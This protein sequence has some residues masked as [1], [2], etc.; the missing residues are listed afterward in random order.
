MYGKVKEK[1]IWSYWYDPSSCPTSKSCVM[2]PQVELCV[3]T[4]QHNKGGFD[5]VVLHM[6]TV[7][8]YLNGY[9]LPFH[10]RELTAPHQ[11]D[12][13]MNALLAR[14][15]GVALDIS[16]IVLRP[17]DPWWEEMVARGATFR[18]YVYRLDGRP[19]RHAE[20]TAVWFM[21]SRRE[22]IFSAATRSQVEGMGDRRNVDG[23]YHD[24]NFALGDQTVTPILSKFNYSLPKCFQDPSLLEP[25]Q[26]CPEW[27]QPPWYEG[28]SG[29]ERNDTWLMLEDPRTGPHLPFAMS[30]MSLWNTRNSTSPLPPGDPR[31]PP[32]HDMGGPMQS[33]RCNSMKECWEEVVLRRYVT[34]QLSFVKLFAHGDELSSRSREALLEDRDTYFSSFLRL[35]GLPAAIAADGLPEA[36]AAGTALG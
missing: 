30:G 1:T 17:L 21:M 28:L 12:A 34:S 5:H 4:A 20:V 13:I 31:F 23:V 26:R 24:A 36:I 35:A 8:L 14:Y 19:W 7:L 10:W 25:K 27:E 9:E 2:P 29:P 22:G 33:E 6:D 18:G 3:A 15:G 32:S 11:K 16:S